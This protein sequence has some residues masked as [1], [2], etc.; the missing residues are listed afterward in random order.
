[1]AGRPLEQVIAY[2]RRVAAAPAPAA[3]GDGSLLE[4]FLRDRDQA[5]FAELVRRHGPMVLALCRRLLE[6]VHGAEDAFQATFL[7]LARKAASVRQRGSVGSFLYGV[8]RRVAGKAR[9][10]MARR[11]V[12]EKQVQPPAPPDP[13]EEVA[14][15]ELR[16]VLDEELGRLPE[17]YRAPLVLCYLEGKTNEEAARAL[18]WTKGTV[19]GR[20]ARA[21]DLLRP[22]LARRGLAL[23]AAAVAGAVAASAAPAA[24]PTA[25]LET[26]ARAA[27]LFAAGPGA[28]GVVSRSAITL[29]EGV[30]R[31]MFLKRV[32]TGAA[33]LLTLAV[34]GIGGTVVTY[35]GLADEPKKA[36]APKKEPSPEPARK[37][38]DA[39][40]KLLD[41]RVEAAKVMVEARKEEFDAGRGTL[42]ILLEAS[43][44]Y[45]EA[46]LERTTKR[47]ERLAALEAQV[48]LLKELEDVSKARYDQG[49]LSIADYKQT[50]YARANAEIGLAREKAKK[51]KP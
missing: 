40:R 29:G 51:D 27:V 10:Q 45:T 1:M 34:L 19:S 12:H 33:L 42:D 11:R 41:E 38:E 47:A 25:L 3:D 50:Q 46:E 14:R 20:L 35:R 30:L 24:V 16:P 15:A 2:A 6:D 48:K 8:A 17:K 32:M 18:G 49:R 4:R 23:S 36:D 22:R 7:V 26:A 28:A 5:A 44:C 37:E 39:L 13:A 21:R 9:S 31:A 43:R